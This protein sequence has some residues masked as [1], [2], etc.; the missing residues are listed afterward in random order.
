M[1]H[2]T[3]KNGHMKLACI[4]LIL[5]GLLLTGLTGCSGGKKYQVDYC[6]SKD[7][8][9]NARDSYRAG[10]EVTLYFEL[11]AT[12]TEYS[13]R[14][15]GEPIRYTYDDQKGFVIRFTMPDHDVKLEWDSYNSML[16][17]ESE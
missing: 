3:A 8:Y 7:C 16:P 11:V 12:D 17:M 10:T 6:G 9:S 13:F 14:L 5:L 1:R 4:A 2:P 15:D